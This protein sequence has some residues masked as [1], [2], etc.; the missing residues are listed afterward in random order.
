MGSVNEKRDE[1]AEA[2]AADYA[3][4]NQMRDLRMTLLD[5]M[6]NPPSRLRPR[7]QDRIVALIN[8]LKDNEDFIVAVW[9]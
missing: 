8:D 6:D 3:A 4:K 7:T 2:H 9:E 1:M 5:F